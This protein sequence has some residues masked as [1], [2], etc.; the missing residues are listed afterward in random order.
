MFIEITVHTWDAVDKPVF[1]NTSHIVT[2]ESDKSRSLILLADGTTV[3]AEESL[4]TLIERI[5]TE[6]I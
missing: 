1:I 2:M 6:Q 5:K 3:V 4:Y